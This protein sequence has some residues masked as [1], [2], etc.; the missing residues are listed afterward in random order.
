MAVILVAPSEASVFV[1]ASSV[2]P[3]PVGASRGHLL[4]SLD[5]QGGGRYDQQPKPGQVPR[6]PKTVC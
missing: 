1:V 2:I 6:T 5:G 3:L 4:T